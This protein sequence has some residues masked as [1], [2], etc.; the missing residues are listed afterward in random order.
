[1]S[2]RSAVKVV[3]P[4]PPLPEIAIFMLESFCVTDD[5]SEEHDKPRRILPQEKL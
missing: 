2:A 4:V 5:F 3:L 1:V